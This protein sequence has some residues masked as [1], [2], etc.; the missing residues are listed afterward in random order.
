MRDILRSRTCCDAAV[1]F[2]L[3]AR[4]VT[5]RPSLI[6]AV[7]EQAFAIALRRRPSVRKRGGLMHVVPREA[8][9]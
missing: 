2:C 3:H 7:D 5:V 1:K 9:S 4:E 8:S 6:E